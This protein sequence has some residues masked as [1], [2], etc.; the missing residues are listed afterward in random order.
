MS[1]VALDA[2]AAVPAATDDAAPDMV[3][4]RIDRSANEIRRAARPST[5]IGD[6]E[7][8]RAFAVLLVLFEHA[9]LNLVFWNSILLQGVTRYLRG[10]VGVDLFFAISGFVIA[11]TLLPTLARCRGR[12]EFLVE[13]V[14][15]W[16]RR[17]WRLLPSA[18]LW[19]LIPLL[20][21]VAFNRSGVFMGFR[22]NFDGLV[23]GMLDVAN[24]R[25]G[26]IYG[27]SPIG[28][29]FPYWSLSLEEQ[30]YLV[31]PV[32]AFLFRRH[33]AVPLI[34]LVV[35]QFAVTRTPMTMC[36]RTGAIS[37]GV[38]L[39]LWQ[40]HPSYRLFEPRALGRSRLLRLAVVGVPLLFMAA[41]GSDD[42]AIVSFRV[43]MIAL[44]AGFLVWVA[45]YDRGYVW[46]DGPARRLLLWIAARSYALYLIHVPVYLGMHE[47]WF[48]AH[49]HGP[50]MRDTAPHGAPAVLYVLAAGAVLLALA[51]LNYRLFETKLRRRGAVVAAGF[52]AG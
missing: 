9:S 28:A 11:R 25:T 43:G 44:L 29:S 34:L 26:M 31:L 2:R 49:L 7:V 15:F 13:T 5:R 37:L 21:C 38:L 8:L 51:D 1:E 4:P 20:L 42:A 48:R 17:A 52:G 46:Q 27:R 41:L 14:R 16:I 30:F 18:W 19:L 40:T 47:L 12:D 23:A 50:A 39:A 22:A 10:W 33:L 45:S 24:F 32:A 36:L 35:L 6:I 3:S